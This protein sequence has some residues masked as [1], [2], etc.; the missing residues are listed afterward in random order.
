MIYHQNPLLVGQLIIQGFSSD[1]VLQAGKQ[2]F[3]GLVHIFSG[4]RA[5]R[6][7]HST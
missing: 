6:R 3:Y 5:K 4:L 1:M 7:N 2:S